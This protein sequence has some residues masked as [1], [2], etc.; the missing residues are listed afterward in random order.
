[1]KIPDD[2]FE[3][4]CRWCWH[5]QPGTDNQDWPQERVFSQYWSRQQPCKIFGLCKPLDVPGECLTFT[6]HPFSHYGICLSCAY[7]NSFRDGYCTRPGGPLN[8]RQIY[9]GEEYHSDYF[10]VHGLSTCDLYAANP[11][12]YDLMRRDAAAGLVPQIF[13]PET[14]QPIGPTEYNDAAE[15]WRKIEDEKRRQDAAAE[16]ARQQKEEELSYTQSV[17]DGF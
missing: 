13:D 5:R 11:N 6:P 16:V 7:T 1:M 14:M 3:T 12:F 9:L 10:R 8:K 2:V 4:R 15:K 17:M